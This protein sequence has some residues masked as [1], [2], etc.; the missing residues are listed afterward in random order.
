MLRYWILGIGAANVLAGGV[1]ALQQSFTIPP[2]DIAIAFLVQLVCMYL[3]SQL[4]S[5]SN[6]P[7]IGPSQGTPPPAALP[8][9]K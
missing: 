9:L 8:P 1:M 6:P 2:V 5:W 7:K 3:L 4:D